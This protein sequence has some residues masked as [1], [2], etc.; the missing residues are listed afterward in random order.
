MSDVKLCKDC[1]H[2][3]PNTRVWE[4]E[5]YRVMYAVCDKTIS[6]VDGW[7]TIDCRDHRGATW[8]GARIFNRCGAEGRWFEPKEAR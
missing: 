1:K 8:L 3:V 6:N 5:K 2:F 4:A 7:P